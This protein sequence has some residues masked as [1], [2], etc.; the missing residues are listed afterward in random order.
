MVNFNPDVAKA[1]FKAAEAAIA[2]KRSVTEEAKAAG[3]SRSAVTEARL[4]L[5]FGT[6]QQK[7][8]ALNY[9]VG[10]RTIAKAIRK[11]LPDRERRGRKRNGPKPTDPEYLEGIRTDMEL[12]TRFSVAIKNLSQMPNTLDMLRVLNANSQRKRSAEQYINTATKWLEDFANEWNKQ[13]NSKNDLTDSG[14]GNTA[15]GTQYPKSAA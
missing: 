11:S 5:E 15:S 9:R 4:V 13:F 6:D 14:G 1:A 2:G 3:V 10:I 12:W 7:E 8:D